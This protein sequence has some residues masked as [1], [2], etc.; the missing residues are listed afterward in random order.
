MFFENINKQ[1]LFFVVVSAFQLCYC[2]TVNCRLKFKVVFAFDKMNSNDNK[3]N[4][5][6]VMRYALN[7]WELNI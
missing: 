1:K 2:C 6:S 3:R 7:K 4:N 5:A